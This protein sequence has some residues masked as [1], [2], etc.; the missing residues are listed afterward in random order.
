MSCYIYQLPSWVLDDLCRNMDTL[1]EWDWMQFGEWCGSGPGWG[2]RGRD[3][4]AAPGLPLLRGRRSGPQK[5]LPHYLV[6]YLLLAVSLRNVSA[7]SSGASPGR[8]RFPPVFPEPSIADLGASSAPPLLPLQLNEWSLLRDHRPDPAAEDPVHGAGA[9]LTR[10]RLWW[11]GMRQATVQQ[12][13]DLLCRLELYRAAQIVLNSTREHKTW[14][15]FSPG[16]LETCYWRW[17]CAGPS[18]PRPETGL[19]GSS[20]GS[21]AGLGKQVPEVRSSIPAFPDAVKP[22]RPS[23]RNT[24]DAQEK[25]PPVTPAVSPGPGSVPAG[26]H[27]Q[28]LLLPLSEEDA[29]RSLKASLPAA[30]DSKVSSTSVPKQ[31][32]LWSLA[33]DNFFWSEADVVQATNNFNQN[34]KIHEGTFADVYRGQRQGLP[35]VF[36]KLKETA[37]SSPGSAERFFQA[38]I[39]ICLRTFMESAVPPAFADPE[40]VSRQASQELVVQWGGRCVLSSSECENGDAGVFRGVE[41]DREGFCA[42]SQFHSLIYPHMEN[43][44]LQDRLQGQDSADPLSWPQRIS[45]CLAL[46][47]AVEHLHSLEIIHGNIKSSNVL[48][49]RNFTPKLA[50]ARAHPGP[51]N[52]RSKYTM[53]RTQLFQAS[54]AYL[55]EDFI[56]VGQLTQRVD[57]F[58]C[59]IVLAEVLTGIPAM[60]NN[61]SPVYLKDL[62]LSE[63]PSGTV[64][65]CSRK[66]DVEK[67]MA[68]E[69]CQQYLEKRAGRLPED[70]AEALA[71]AVCL[72]LRRRNAS[73]E[74]VCSSVAAVEER[75]RGHH[76]SLPWSRLSEGTGSSCNTPEETDDVDNSSLDASSSL[77]AAPWA[78]SAASPLPT[79]NGEGR[80]QA[81]RDVEADSC[82]EA[83]T[84]SEP[85]QDATKTSWNI[86]INEAKRKLMENI[87]LYKEEKLDSMELFGP[88]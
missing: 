87:L 40:S 66:T 18:P 86:E 71:T 55:P 32:K 24:E 4:P 9:G 1:S 5:V 43:G 50:H 78:G 70:C 88:C 29:P 30:P 19:L 62:L 36:K 74:E 52:Q 53:M 49:D 51:V 59:G 33:G 20:E 56:R 82:S 44:S 67:V 7:S 58:S 34:H 61:R 77:R 80:L 68:R 42:G 48:L 60:D 73:L 39:Q 75:L 41:E 45:I 37:C 57:I 27:P 17:H 6:P 47:R 14:L 38:E 65:L 23:V 72:C 85:Q 11:W 16:D 8:G 84:G 13:V 22:G 69:I 3:L 81:S 25:G 35:F 12:L 31:E 83:C 21:S 79:E 63:I 2:V 54:A 64:S 26:A 46:L 28:A 76:T 10:E 15:G